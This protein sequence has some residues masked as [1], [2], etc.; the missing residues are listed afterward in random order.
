MNQVKLVFVLAAW[1][2]Q[3]SIAGT[4]EPDRYIVVRTA[5]SSALRAIQEQ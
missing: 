5:A 2:S 1:L 3:L 4:L